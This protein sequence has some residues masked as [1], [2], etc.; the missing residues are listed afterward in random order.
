MEESTSFYTSSEK[1]PLS[2]ETYKIIGLAMEV[3]KEIGKGFLE[4]VYKDALEIEFNDNNVSY[5]REKPYEINYKGRLLKRQYIADFVAFNQIILE[6]KD[7]SGIYD[8]DI[9]QTINYLACS[10]LHIGLIINFG[11]ESLTFR[12]VILT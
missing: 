7:Q 10:K 8:E 4:I 12:R 9:K 6:I 5:E 11:E 3:H 1:Y 2:K